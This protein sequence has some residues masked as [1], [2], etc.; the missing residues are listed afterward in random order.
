MC[1]GHTNNLGGNSII[2]GCRLRSCRRRSVVGALFFR[3]NVGV[4]HRQCGVVCR[5]P[6]NASGCG[7]IVG[8]VP[9]NAC[10]IVGVVPE[11]A[12]RSAS[13]GVWGFPG[14][15]ATV[16]DFGMCRRGGTCFVGGVSVGAVGRH[17]G[18][19]VGVVGLLAETLVLRFKEFRLF[20][21]VC[22]GFTDPTA[23]VTWGR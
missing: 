9:G 14:V 1:S 20:G 7:I 15:H 22:G 8:V 23:T 21:G 3:K 11:S 5:S 19:V 13:V 6:E 17:V 4:D 12:L 10:G 16:S 18:D 2:G